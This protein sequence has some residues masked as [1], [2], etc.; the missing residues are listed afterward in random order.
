MSLYK[1][2]T[3]R[4]TGGRRRRQRGGVSDGA[5][6]EATASIVKALQNGGRR[7]TYKRSGS[8]RSGSKRRSSKR[9]GSK[10]RSRMSG[11]LAFVL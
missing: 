2:M 5:L 4:H 10:R 9:R 11:G 8:K 7:R 6:N 1:E 3:T